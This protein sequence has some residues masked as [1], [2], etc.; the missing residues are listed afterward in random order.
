QQGMDVARINCA[1]DGPLVW[2]RMIRHIRR[3]EKTQG[4][5]CRILMDLAGPK[6]RTG[7]VED[8]QAVGEVRPTRTALGAVV[9]PARVWIT[10][11][12]KPACP[13]TEADASLPVPAEWISRLSRGDRIR[14]CDARGA[15]RD[16]TVVDITN[17]GCWAEMSKTAYITPGTRLTRQG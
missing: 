11:S 10:G 1:H 5:T 9:R 8:G 16:M 3:A 2:E 13:P 12:K 17:E 15:R 6:L 7:P 14:F 4:R